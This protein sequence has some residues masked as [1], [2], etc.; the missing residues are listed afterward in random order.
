MRKVEVAANVGKFSLSH[1]EYDRFEFGSKADEITLSEVSGTTELD[2]N[3][4]VVVR[5]HSF[6]GELSLNQMNAVST[7]Y[8]PKDKTVASRCKGIGTRL[9]C[10]T[11]ERFAGD[12]PDIIELNGFHSELTVVFE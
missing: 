7:M 12:A 11:P 4:N 1:L 2:V 3:S 10:D 5:A 6:S 8:L 9:L